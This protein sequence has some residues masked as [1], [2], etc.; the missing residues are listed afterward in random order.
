MAAID[1]AGVFPA[2]TTQYRPDM[3]VDIAA[4][5]SVQDALI[6]DGVH[7]LVLMGTVGEGNS[8][9]ADEKRN[10]LQAAVEVTAGRVPVIA[11]VSELSTALACAFARDAEKL[12]ASGLMVLPSMVY[13]PTEEELIAHFRAVAQSTSLPIMLYNNPP[14][15]RVNIGIRTMEALADQPN[16]VCLKES[17][18]DTRRYTD[19]YNIMGDRYVLFAGLD[20]VA[21]EAL[22]L[23][24]AGWISGLTNAFPQESIALYDAFR[25]GDMPTALAIYRWFMPLLHLDAEHDLVQSI[26]LAEQIMGRGSE[27]VRMPR[28]PLVGARRAEVIAMVEKAVASRPALKAAA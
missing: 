13:V 20:D 2:A 17:S 7:G 19:I 8:L 25:R 24:A 6:R 9:L 4:T 16:V 21:L 28:L 5:Q 11:G 12:G 10:V 3:S 15:Y 14:S 23:G 26:K 1:W 18:T 27:R 22:M